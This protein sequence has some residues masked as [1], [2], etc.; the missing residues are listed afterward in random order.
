VLDPALRR[1]GRF[2]REIAISIPD[3]NGRLEILQIHTPGMPLAGDVVLEVGGEP[4]FRGQGGVAALDRWL[5]R[6][7]RA[8]AAAYTIRLLRQ[9]APLDLT[10][11]LKLGPYT[12]PKSA[13]SP[14]AALPPAG[15]RSPSAGLPLPRTARPFQTTRARHS[16]RPPQGTEDEATALPRTSRMI[17]FDHY[18]T[19][20]EIETYLQNATA[21]HAGISRLIQIG[22]SR[23]GRRILAVEIN[24]P[25]TGEAPGKPGFYVDGNIH[26][27]ELLGGEAA[28]HFIDALLGGGGPGGILEDLVR[29]TAFY[30]V[31][32]VNPDGREVSVTT[33]E[34]HRWN[35]RPVDEDGDGRLDEDP[36]EDLDGDGRILQMRIKDPHGKWLISPDDPRLMIQRQQ[37]GD[38]ATR[39][40]ET[41]PSYSVYTEGLDN[42]NDG[43]FN[44]DSTGGVDVNRNFPANWIPS[45]FAAGPY[46]LSE[47]ESRALV[48]YITQRPAISAIHTFHTSGGMILRFPTLADQDWDFPANDLK[49]YDLL[50]R[51]GCRFTDYDNFAFAKKKIVDLM[52]PGHGVFNDWASNVFGVFAITTELWKHPWDDLQLLAWNDKILAGRG[53]VDWHPYHHPQLGDV[54]LGGWDRYSV[55]NPPESMIRKE[56]QGNTRWMISFARSLPRVAILS[57]TTRAAGERDD[58]LDL[59]ARVANIGRLPTSTRY[60]RETLKIVPPIVAELNLHGAELVSGE[61]RLEM[62]VLPGASEGEA[63]PVRRLHWRVRRQPGPAARAVLT[64]SSQKAGTV[65]REMMLWEDP[66]RP[67][68]W[69]EGNG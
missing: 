39:R 12:G 1:P 47:P 38:R 67:A 17:R 34:N 10:V 19:M 11:R 50:A 55:D 32:V 20:E 3:K 36:P 37:D 44:E 58:F 27:G 29:S 7:L 51:R 68:Q 2:D 46:P 30:I 35:A 40:H 26:G 53:F 13:P 42:D 4:F 16:R 22:K 56:L 59:E 14:S 23:N 65:R 64:V 41:A 25:S 28:L 9:G 60:A 18:H 43:R 6:E 15:F 54:E 24:N 5:R 48:E 31:P 8:T 62:D 66:D 33:P 61:P 57:F 63:G 49:Q 45:Q 21:A 52:H 69:K